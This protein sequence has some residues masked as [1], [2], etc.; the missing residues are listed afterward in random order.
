MRDADLVPFTELLDSVCNLLSRGTYTP[1]AA[2]TALW[3][4]A[5]R[6]HPLDA[7]RAGLD[8]HVRDPQR[9]RFVPTP[10]DVIAQI[11]GTAEADGR[12]GAEEAWAIA[13]R[14]R[15][16]QETVVWTRDIAEALGIARPILDMG[17]EVGARMAFR[18]AYNRIVEDAR[19]VRRPASWE[20]SLGF[21]PVRRDEAIRAGVEAGRLPLEALPP[22]KGADMPLLAL[23]DSPRLRPEV[24]A[25][26]RRLSDSF[27]N[28]TPKPGP[29]AAARASTEA[30]RAE[31][32]QRARAYAAEHGISL[33]LPA[34]ADHSVTP[35]QEATNAG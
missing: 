29:D 5:L 8:A 15:D 9:G 30:Q 33:D 27:K 10:A 32:A 20:T 16:E 35:E 24:Q 21:D 3:F 17:D 6:E 26:L 31:A 23:A 4:R 28:A 14:A 34:P 13:L 7:V 25:E 2:N 22:P 12:P 19:R 1:N 11:V 18:E